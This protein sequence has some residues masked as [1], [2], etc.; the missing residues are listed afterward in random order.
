MG[1]TQLYKRRKFASHWDLLINDI[2]CALTQSELKFVTYVCGR[3]NEKYLQ[4][5]GVRTVLVDAQ[6]LPLGPHR[7]ILQNRFLCLE[8]ALD[9]LDELVALDW[10]CRLC[11]SLPADFW[12][13]LG[14]K[15]CFQAPLGRYSYRQRKA[16]WRSKEMNLAP[17]G[18]FIYLRG[19]EVLQQMLAIIREGNTEWMTDEEV[20]AKWSDIAM[21]GW[22]G[23]AAYFA[24]FEPAFVS[25][26]KQ[27]V[28]YTV[29]QLA[30]KRNCFAHRHAFK[31]H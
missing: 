9:D 30:E 1:W 6:P 23:P 26:D 10:D 4:D 7:Q 20:A 12:E 25:V 3:E 14:Q 21:G 19:R 18:G 15:D 11:C 2:R 24:R 8:R 5:L 27:D 29:E 17:N 28:F 22:G 31:P 16:P 13:V